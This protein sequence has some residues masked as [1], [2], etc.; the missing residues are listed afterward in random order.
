MHKLIDL[1]TCFP[2]PLGGHS[3][4]AGGEDDDEG[5]KSEDGEKEDKEAVISSEKS[6]MQAIT[7]IYKNKFVYRNTKLPRI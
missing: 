2:G 7:H 5:D 4:G 1:K 6:S 3:N